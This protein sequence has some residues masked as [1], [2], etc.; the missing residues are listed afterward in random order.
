MDVS[1][2]VSSK[3]TGRIKS[4]ESQVENL[5]SALANQKSQVDVE[6]LHLKDKLS[7]TQKQLGRFLLKEEKTREYIA[8]VTE[9]VNALDPLP[10]VTFLKPKKEHAT[11]MT[12][13]LHLTDWHI[14]SVISPKETE[15]WGNFDWAIAQDRIAGQLVPR[16]KQWLDTMRS[17]YRIDNI[18]I[19][20]TGDFVSGDIHDELLRTN[21]F[22]L[23]VQTAKAGD[24]LGHVGHELAPHC[25]KLIFTQIGADNHSRL[26]R[27]PQAKQKAS[28]SMSF[29]VYHIANKEL[30]KHTN[31][32]VQQAEGMK[33]LFNV[34]NFPFLGEHG[35]SVKSWM[36]VPYYGIQRE[37]AREARRRMFDNRG[38]KFLIMGH[39]HEPHFSDIIV[40]GCLPGTDEYDH[41]CGRS[42]APQQTA[43]LVGKRGPFNFVPFQL[44]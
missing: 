16:F 32:E 12:A 18:H 7:V 38:F 11:P 5:K 25:E 13:V 4:L 17:G 26:V 35:D 22:P 39:W 42:G 44:Q 30:A 6:K 15:G 27:K 10:R 20:A 40:G 23:P 33:L 1:Q 28:N 3:Y 24:L 21:E 43:F 9:A 37:Q 36:G 34:G 2:V 31:I 8:E 14:G 41:S 19:I 29:L